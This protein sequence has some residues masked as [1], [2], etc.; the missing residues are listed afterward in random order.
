MN[1]RLLNELID[2]HARGLGWQGWRVSSDKEIIGL[3]F[4]TVFVGGIGLASSN[5][6]SFSVIPGG[7]IIVVP[8]LCVNVESRVILPDLKL[9]FNFQQ[10]FRF[11]EDSTNN[12]L[13]QPSDWK[14]HPIASDATNG[15]Y[16]Y[17][18]DLGFPCVFSVK[19]DTK[20]R[21]HSIFDTSGS[22]TLFSL[23]CWGT[24]LLL[25]PLKKTATNPIPLTP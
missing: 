9:L 18:I 22:P 23:T 2:T 11:Y 1:E 20:V 21:V 8:S 6:V 19:Q 4:P 17:R 15:K 14:I 13:A 16:Y 25:S 5:N 24:A 3:S 7:T 10:E 12:F